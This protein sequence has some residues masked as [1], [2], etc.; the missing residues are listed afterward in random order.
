MMN[1]ITAAS[2]LLA[3]GSAFFLGIGTA[4]LWMTS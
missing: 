1:P 3:T 4:L 2:V